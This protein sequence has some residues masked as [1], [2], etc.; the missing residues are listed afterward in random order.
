MA[1]SAGDM[2]LPM[3]FAWC[4]RGRPQHAAGRAYVGFLVSLV[5]LAIWSTSGP[6][7]RKLIGIW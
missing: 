3:R 6:G 7:W 1:A 5:H 2:R 4:A